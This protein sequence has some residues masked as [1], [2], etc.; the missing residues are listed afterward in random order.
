[1]RS[2]R[3]MCGVSRKDRCRDSDVRERCG[4]K[5]DV[6]TGVERGVW[7]RFWFSVGSAERLNLFPLFSQDKRTYYH[8]IVIEE[9]TGLRETVTTRCVFIPHGAPRVKRDESPL[10][11]DFHEPEVVTLTD[12]ATEHAPDPQLGAAVKQ[13]GK[14]V[15]GEISVSPGTPLSMEIFLDNTS[16]P[17]YG[18]MV[19]YMHVTDTDKQQETIIFNG[20]HEFV[21]GL[22]RQN[23]I[24]MEGD[25]VD[26]NG[27]RGSGSPEFPLTERNA[28]AVATTSRLYSVRVRRLIDRVGPFLCCIQLGHH[29]LDIGVSIVCIVQRTKLCCSESPA[30]DAMRRFNAP[31]PFL[32]LLRVPVR[33]AFATIFTAAEFRVLFCTCSVDPYVFDNFLTDDGKLLRAKFRAFKFPDSTYV[34]FKATVLIV[35]LQVT[36]LPQV[37][38]SNG[39]T[40]YG[41][42]RRAVDAAASNRLYEVALTTFIKVEGD[43]QGPGDE[44]SHASPISVQRIVGPISDADNQHP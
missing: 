42:R 24:S 43:N 32:L 10:P 38:C 19:S 23:K 30:N 41:R 7:S 8:K 44:T 1:M 11:L 13:D 20:N 33:N 31:L 5:E 22:L 21:A 12:M 2:L 15:S 29:F 36:S 14:Q 28:T 4:V 27:R 37:E 3:S 18:L 40:A 17:I 9:S 16:A 26:G 25:R 34:Q 35:A 39:V 6:V